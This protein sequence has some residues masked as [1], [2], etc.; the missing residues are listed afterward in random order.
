MPNVDPY[1]VS[2]SPDWMTAPNE[3][4]GVSAVNPEAGEFDYGGVQDFA[5]AAWQNSMRYLDPQLTQQD[6]RFAQQLINQGIDPYS[7]AGQRAFQQK[8]MSQNDLLSKSAFDALG[9]GAGLQ[10][11]MFG[12]DATRSQLANALLQSQW[13][14]TQRGHEFDI[15]AGMQ[16]NEQAFNQMLGLEGLNYRDY[17]TMIDQQ[18]YQDSLALALAGLA[19]APQ[20]GT[21]STGLPNAPI[22]DY[23][24]SQNTW[25]DLWS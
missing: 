15:G 5:D 16:A 24:G 11:Q 19:P 6:E 4:G 12:Q 10:N 1:D 3:I 14:L 20:Y 22:Y 25:A 18:R 9:Y 8:E 23:Q 17:Q 7:E 2:Q 21:V 13:G